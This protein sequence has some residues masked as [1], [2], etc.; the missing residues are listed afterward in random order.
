[1]KKF[2]FFLFLL[3][4]VFV[5]KTL[6]QVDP[7]LTGMISSATASY[8][9]TS[10]AQESAMLLIQEGHIWTLGEESSITS[11]Q[12]QFNDYLDNFRSLLAY[13]AEIYGFYYEIGKLT[14][15]M[16]DLSSL[17]SKYP[18]NA[19]AVLLYPKK[20]SI[21]SDLLLDGV[22]IIN[23]VRLICFSDT[24]MTEKERVEICLGIR[25][26]LKKMNR[27]LESLNIAVKFTS[28]TDVW[29][30]VTGKPEKTL[31]KATIC[32]QALSRWQGSAKDVKIR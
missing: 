24:K 28:L 10:K 7:V 4:S 17:L 18:D 1:M 13:A 16:G 8:K 11:W 5:N 25:P 23:D 9:K 31:D 22:E 3:G 15:N 30:Y 19:F 14:E 26:K 32:R 2:I 21:Y 20:N 29:K 6:A 12:R 27:H